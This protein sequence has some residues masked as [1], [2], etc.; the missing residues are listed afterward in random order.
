MSPNLPETDFAGQR[1]TA[2]SSRLQAEAQLV[3]KVC[4]WIDMHL[5]EDI[6]WDRLVRISGLPVARLKEVFVRH[7][8]T[9]PMMYIRQR[10]TESR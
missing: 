7:L 5:A 6:D 4:A 9:T 10:R 8:K 1:Q 3:A 2:P